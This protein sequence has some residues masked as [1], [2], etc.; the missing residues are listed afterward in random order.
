MELLIQVSLEKIGTGEFKLYYVKEDSV[1][2]IPA[3]LLSVVV[4]QIRSLPQAG[5]HNLQQPM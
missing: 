2:I 1:V 3:V 5:L 4:T